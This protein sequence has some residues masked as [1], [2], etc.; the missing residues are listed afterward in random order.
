MAACERERQAPGLEPRGVQVLLPAAE[1]VL[2]LVDVQGER[3]R[4]PRREMGGEGGLAAAGSA[5]QQQEDRGA[6]P[7]SLAHVDGRR[8]R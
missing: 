7:C 3:A 5:V 2:Q 4:A 6:H 8:G 1:G